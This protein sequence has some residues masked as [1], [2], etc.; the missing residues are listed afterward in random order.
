[1]ARPRKLNTEE[2]LRI[3]DAFYESNG[4]PS[5]LKYSLIEGYAVSLGFIVK[6]YD[7]RRDGSVR[8]R[9]DELKNVAK[10]ENIALAYKSMD[11]DALLHRNYTREMLKTG[12]MELDAYW[13]SIYEAAAVLTEKNKALLTETLSQ[14][15]TIKKLADDNASLA[16]QSKGNE[17]KANAL[18]LENRHL[19]NSIKKYLYP[20][21]A[22]EILKNKG[23]LAHIETTVMPSAMDELTEPATPMPF[24]KS[25]DSDRQMLSREESLLLRMRRKGHGNQEKSAED[26]S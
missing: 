18:I 20:A 8:Q 15:T 24:S 17:R 25:V 22:N 21:I 2:M 13:R 4:D 11:V 7:F 23:S 14:K 12:L 5:R 3:V 9:I 19:K 1:M 16:E 6:A 26:N 10:P